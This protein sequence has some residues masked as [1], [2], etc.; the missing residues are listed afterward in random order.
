M[1]EARGKKGA[2]GYKPDVDGFSGG[3]Q[4][5]HK[6]DVDGILGEGQQKKQA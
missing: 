1:L 3:Q 6:P 5:T 2:A 4:K